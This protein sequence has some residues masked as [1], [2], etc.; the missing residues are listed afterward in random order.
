MAKKKYIIGNWKMNPVLLKDARDLIGQTLDGLVR[1]DLRDIEVVLSVPY[2]WIPLVREKLRSSLPEV[3]LGAQN[4]SW[5]KKGTLTGEI[6]PIMLKDMDVEYVIIGHSERRRLLSESDG[7]INKKVL[8]ALKVGLKVV[9]A[10]GS[11]KMKRGRGEQKRIKQQLLLG[12]Y[13]VKPA[14]LRNLIIAYEPT[15]AISQGLGKGSPASAAYVEEKVRQIRDVISG[16]YGREQARLQKIIYGGSSNASNILNYLKIR[17]VNGV[18]PGGASLVAR[19]FVEM[20]RK[21]ADFISF[22]KN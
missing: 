15:W 19:E 12:L 6:S 11:E 4:V 3:K 2:I 21:T 20:V 18:L 1:V 22:S 14:Y 13:G 5:Q 8:L 10:V 17:G 16:V 7:L 9:L